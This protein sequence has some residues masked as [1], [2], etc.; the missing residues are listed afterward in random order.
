L[1]V[2]KCL[3]SLRLRSAPITHQRQSRSE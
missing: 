3:Q 1:N 2:Q